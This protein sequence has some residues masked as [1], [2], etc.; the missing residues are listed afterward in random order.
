MKPTFKIM[1]NR[2][3]FPTLLTLTLATGVAHAATGT[4]NG[5]AG[6]G[7]GFWNATANTEWSGVTGNAWDATNGPNN[8]AQFNSGTGANIGTSGI[9]VAN[10]II[11]NGVGGGIS[12]GS[13]RLDGTNPFVSVSAGL[14]SNFY[15]NLLGTNGFTKTGAGT[16]YLDGGG[17]VK[18]ITGGITISQ[19]GMRLVL[20]ASPNVANSSN[21]L[22]LSGSQLEVFGNGTQTLS[23]FTLGNGGSRIVFTPNGASNSTTLSLANWTKASNSSVVIDLA[24]TN[25]TAKTLTLTGTLPTLT[26]SLI[27]GYATVRDSSTTY[28]FATL[29]GSNNVVRYTDATTVGAALGADTVSTTNY[30]VTAGGVL[31]NGSSTT[32]SL[33]SLDIAITQ[34]NGGTTTISGTSGATYVLD[35]GGL[36]FSGNSTNGNVVANMTFT[37]ATSEL[38]IAT[39]QYNNGFAVPIIGGVRD[40]GGTK[41]SLVKAGTG[42]LS[43]GTGTFSYTG[44]TIVNDGVLHNIANIP[45]GSGKGNLV[46]NSRGIVAIGVGAAGGTRTIN[47]LSN[48]TLAGGTVNNQNFSGTVAS[49]FLDLGNNDATASFSGVISGNFNIIKSGT[50]TQTLSGANTYAGTTAVNAGTLALVGGSQASPITVNSSAALGFTVGSPTTSSSTV[51]FNASSKVKVTGTPAAVTLMTASSITGTPVLDPAIPGY[52][53]EVTATE[54]KLVTGGATPYDTW[55]AIYLPADV[56]NPAGDNDNDGLTNQQEFAF[57]LNPTSGSSVNPTLVQL[58]K[59]AGTFSYQRRAGTGLTYKILKS[60]TLDV[61]S[62]VEDVG[63]SQVATASGENENVVVTLSGAPLTGDKLFVRVAAQ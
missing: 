50:G 61:G 11:W 3:L 52:T 20:G 10:G 49:A 33:Y 35:S 41:V 27:G 45:S 7:D 24:A 56:S 47:G 2:Q 6:G 54:L 31:F 62:W 60:T 16:M 37:S 17:G 28:G 19:G 12:S 59:T 34:T 57:G 58:D 40:N 23:D 42:S 26:N 14:L 44:D 55:A 9:P 1:K 63:A 21:T 25:G 29:D 39:V 51:T 36:L 38:Q 4:W 32:Q 8:V 5:T 18:S 22:N 13:V 53:L 30:K 15:A 46:V 48:T 43:M